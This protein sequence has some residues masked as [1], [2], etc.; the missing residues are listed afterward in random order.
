M[1]TPILTKLDIYRAVNTQVLKS[2][3]FGIV[4]LHNWHNKLG[5]I[6]HVIRSK[7]RPICDSFTPVF[8]LSFPHFLSTACVYLKFGWFSGLF[9]SFLIDPVELHWFWF[10]DTNKNCSNTAKKLLE[11]MF[12]IL[13]KL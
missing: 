3:W 9:V 13:K 8:P 5:P 1:K 6:F 7:T 2:N 11:N 4:L 10:L 12:T